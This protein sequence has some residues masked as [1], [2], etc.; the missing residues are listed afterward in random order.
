MTFQRIKNQPLRFSCMPSLRRCLSQGL[1]VMLVLGLL[2]QLASGQVSYDKP[3][4]NYGSAQPKDAVAKLAEALDGGQVELQ[5]DQQHGW[6]P[7]LLEQLEICPDTQT[8]V[9][10]KT[11][12][13]LHKIS[14]RTPRA[15]YFSDDVYV[16]WCRSGDVIELA[17]T[18]PEN[19][20]MFY[21][22]SQSPDKPAK[23]LRDR[24]QCLT[25]HA[26]HRTQGVPGFLIRSIYPDN[27]GR[28]RSGTRTYVTDHTTEFDKRFG[29]WFVTGKHGDIRHMGNSIARD[30]V[31]PEHLM[32]DEAANL[33]SIADLCDTSRYLRPGSDIVALMVLEHQTQMHNLI[34]RA[35]METR[36]ASYYDR[37][38]NEAL[39]RPLDTVSPS[40]GRRM[41]SAAED[42]IRYMLFA[43]EAPLDS[44]VEGD[45]K[46]RDYFLGD[47]NPSL[48]RD[49]QGRSLRDLDLT[50]RMF[51][52]PCSYLIHSEA[53][54]QL[55]EAMA[56]LV[57]QRLSEILTAKN[58]LEGYERLS[59][60]DRKAILEILAET[61]PG[62]L[63]F[64]AQATSQ[65]Q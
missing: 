4:I 20:A 33:D 28:P 53:F 36:I 14:P 60:A 55:P 40:T 47:A 12:L 45:G 30:R 44:P 62:Y 21:T 3:P 56:E 64:V 6:L 10:S 52:V 15:L 5:Y 11:S 24:G 23:I 54:D 2:N 32:R 19:G 46:F 35:S 37:G 39:G 41:Q 25:C 50:N 1:A 22:V 48:R 18:D 34:A 42:L 65:A 17:A 7:G 13:Q 26:T 31:N 61:K 16:G 57:R 59:N 9:F 63:P 8:L 49:S 27:N 51:K 43:D 58:A 29:G 38:I